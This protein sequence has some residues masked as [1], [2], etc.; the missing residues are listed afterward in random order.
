MFHY[1]LRPF[2]S[3]LGKM[4]FFLFIFPF[5]S[6]CYGSNLGYNS[7]NSFKER[8]YTGKGMF[9]KTLFYYG[10]DMS[11]ITHL[12]CEELDSELGP[13]IGIFTSETLRILDLDGNYKD[14]IQFRWRSGISEPAIR[15]KKEG[16]FEIIA[17]GLSFLGVMDQKGRPM[18]AYNPEGFGSMATGD[19]NQDNLPEYYVAASNLVQLN[20]K[21]EKTW[22]ISKKRLSYN[23]V[24]VLES[25]NG[26][27][28]LLVVSDLGDAVQFLDYQGKVIREIISEQRLSDFQIL[29]WMDQALFLTADDN[30]IFLINLDGKIAFRYKLPH[31]P[32]P[33]YRRRGVPLRLSD[34]KIYLAIVADFSSVTGLSMLC[35]FSPDKE[36]VYQELIKTT[37]GILA[38]KFPS[39]EGEILLVGSGPGRV[40]KYIERK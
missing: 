34:G 13:D 3:P 1:F 25:L 18:W 35:L 17:R 12:I 19:L 27:K 15:L 30:E 37:T 39:S 2:S 4:I 23:Y 36:L 33:I 16:G 26:K 21:G 5:L 14:N 29:F 6:N 28:P 38:V 9:K 10:S 40:Y 20:E 31:C 32:T 24:E 22:E 11:G 7:F 8:I